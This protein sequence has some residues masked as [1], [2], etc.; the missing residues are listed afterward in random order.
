[1]L[2]A[3][4]CSGDV[5]QPVELSSQECVDLRVDGSRQVYAH[6]EPLLHEMERIELIEDIFVCGRGVNCHVDYDFGRLRKG[7]EWFFSIISKQQFRLH[8]DRNKNCT[9][10]T[11]LST[12]GTFLNESLI[13]RGETKTMQSGD[14]IS[15]GKADLHTVYLFIYLFIAFLYEET[16]PTKY[17]KSLT[18]KFI[19]TN[20]SLGK[21]SYGM[22]NC[23]RFIDWIESKTTAYIV[24]EYVAGGELFDRIIDSKWNGQGFGEELG[25]FYAWQLLSA[26]SYIHDHGITHRDI[27]PENIL[28][29]TK[30]DYTIVKPREKSTMKTYCGTPSYIAPEMIDNDNTAYDPKVD[31]WSLGVVLFTGICGYPPFSSDYGDMDMNEQIKN[32]DTLLFILL[33]TLFDSRLFLI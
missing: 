31:I 20:T 16:I 22:P 33:V 21:G 1:M 17:P 30:D 4:E 24:L 12:N 10:I 8:R 29:M 14:V 26:I 3:E 23:L 5:T 7:K 15:V 25:K 9:N 32:G 28:C 13:G 6:L 11:D 27:K 2:D 19:M 18:D